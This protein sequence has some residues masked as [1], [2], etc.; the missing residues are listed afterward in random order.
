MRDWISRATRLLALGL[1]TLSAGGCVDVFEGAFLQFEFQRGVDG[2]ARPGET[3][4]GARPPA[5]TYYAFY[6]V[7]YVYAGCDACPSGT[8]CDEAQ[9]VCLDEDLAPAITDSF[10]FEA[11]R[12]EIQP[13]INTSSPCFIEQRDQRYP[14]LHST[15]VLT[16][17]SADTGIL[18]PTA[19]P[20][21]ATDNDLIDYS[22]AQRRLSLQSQV[23]GGLRAV[24]SVSTADPP[25]VHPAYLVETR[26]DDSDG[27]PNCVETDANFDRSKIP[28]PSCILDE[29][30]A[31]RL[32]R[33]EAYAAEFPDYYEGSD[34]VFTLPLNGRF[35]GAVNGTNPR[36]GVSPIGGAAMF[37]DL[38][39]D[40]FDA[41]LMHWQYK[42]RDGDGEPD[43]PDGTPDNQRPTVGFHYMDGVVRPG[44]RGVKRVDMKNRLFD[45]ISGTVSIV[46]SLGDDTLR[47]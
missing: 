35:F 46:S 40:D 8:T 30:N 29:S 45:E 12:F 34:L 33:C 32:E 3:P 11:T 39:L 18:D 15:Q 27:Q 13:F 43:Y 5:N 21:S 19:P 42:D 17:L 7:R 25:G 9:D 4:E 44:P 23:E 22:T 28:A 47:F 16:R 10:A 36:N 1:L 20:V 6:A 38:A 37:V 24:T 41:L 2:A 26:D 14:G 31:L